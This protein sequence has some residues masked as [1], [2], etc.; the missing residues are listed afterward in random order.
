MFL[1][2]QITRSTLLSHVHTAKFSLTSFS[3][4]GTFFKN[5]SRQLLKKA[6]C[7]GKLGNLYRTHERIKFVKEKLVKAENP[8]HTIKFSST[9]LILSCVRHKL[10]SFLWQVAFF[11]SWRDQ[12]WSKVPF[13]LKQRRELSWSSDKNSCKTIAQGIAPAFMNCIEWNF[14]I[15]WDTLSSS[16]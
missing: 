16:S 11:K 13:T 1:K 12:L 2:T 8:V 3:W 5:W 10:A 4:Q 6:T 14:R 9:N 7:Q 15:M